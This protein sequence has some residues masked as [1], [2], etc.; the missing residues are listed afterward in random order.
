MMG[1]DVLRMK[2]FATR[3][4]TIYFMV[5]NQTIN[6]LTRG[7]SIKDNVCFFGYLLP[8]LKNVL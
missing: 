6:G 1:W 2:I 5:A 3:N 8:E 4:P 7:C